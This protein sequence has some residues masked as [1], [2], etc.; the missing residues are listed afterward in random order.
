MKTQYEQIVDIANIGKRMP[1]NMNDIFAMAEKESFTP[2]IND[3]PRRLL[4]AIDVQND[5]IEGGALAVPNSI[6]DVER[7]TRFIYN[8]M[9]GITKIMC[10]MDTHSPHQ[11]FHPCWWVNSA[12][13]HPAPYT[14]ITHDDVVANRW[15]P[16]IKPV[17]SLNYLKELEK[18]GAGK[19]QLCI[20]PY[21]CI[22][23][24]EGYLIENEFAKMVYFHS[25]ARN[26]YNPIIPKGTDP[27]SE[28]YGI[29][30]PE[31]SESGFINTTVLTS[32]E[33]Y[34]E[35]FV[36]GEAA[37][38]CL[39]ES[40]RQIAEHFA[41]RPEI[42]SKI[43]ILED[44]TSPITGYEAD[45]AATFDTFKNTYGIKFAKSTDIQL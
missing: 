42:T 8:N 24:T 21:H 13:D 39:M 35:I 40:I 31:Y 12:G 3:S 30:K 38:H 10:S 28:M 27:L 15:R 32:I 23:G 20:W 43:T 26:S 29:I 41:N 4:L 33:K 36:V 6:G 7:I 1:Q 5:F 19:K 34:D 17:K 18:A 22:M 44:C 9:E 11:I 25:V 14:V 45:T 2:A 16:L 37:S